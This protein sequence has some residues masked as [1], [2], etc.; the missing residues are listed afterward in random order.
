[1][2]HSQEETAEPVDVAE[3]VAAPDV[4]HEIRRPERSEPRHGP[5]ETPAYR[6]QGE[7]AVEQGGKEDA[8]EV[9]AGTRAGRKTAVE[10]MDA[11]VVVVIQRDDGRVFAPNDRTDPRFGNALRAAALAGVE[12]MA[13]STIVTQ[14]GVD[15]GPSVPVDLH[16][17]MEVDA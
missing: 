7:N 6:R 2:K 10:G 16:A 14:E 17:A 9:L 5:R 12:V 13:Y 1:M 15:L 11:Y 3:A 8:E 4:P